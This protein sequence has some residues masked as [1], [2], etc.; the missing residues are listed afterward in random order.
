MKK[1]NK[2]IKKKL[3]KLIKNSC[4]TK[5]KYK[6]EIIIIKNCFNKDNYEK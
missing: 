2:K 4:L 3:M 5:L 6:N 1:K